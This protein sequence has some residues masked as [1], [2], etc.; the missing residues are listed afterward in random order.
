[1][2]DGDGHSKQLVVSAEHERRAH[3]TQSENQRRSMSFRG[4]RP[5]WTQSRKNFESAEFCDRGTLHS[6]SNFHT[7]KP[8][9]QGTESP[10][11]WSMPGA[12][13]NGKAWAV[14]HEPYA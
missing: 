1:M 2:P 7:N 12:V 14:G 5:S 9:W 3:P 6:E 11:T 8:Y 13:G 4:Y 10:C